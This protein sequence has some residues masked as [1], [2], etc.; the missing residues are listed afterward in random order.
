MIVAVCYVFISLLSN[1]MLIKKYVW[2]QKWSLK[3]LQFNCVEVV[4][5]TQ[6]YRINAFVLDV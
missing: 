2:G 3:E 1:S 4:D 5:Y 6:R